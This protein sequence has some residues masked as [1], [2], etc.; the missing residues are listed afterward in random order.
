[1]QEFLELIKDF[2]ITE[3]GDMSPGRLMFYGGLGLFGLTVVLLIVFLIWRP[4]YV[5]ESAAVRAPTDTQRRQRYHGTTDRLAGARSVSGLSGAAGEPS[6]QAAPA[7]GASG[8]YGEPGVRAGTPTAP[9]GQSAG[10]TEPMAQSASPTA[11]IGQ[12]VSPTA[13]LYPQE[14]GTA[15]LGGGGLSS[16]APLSQGESGPTRPVNGGQSTMPLA[17][18]YERT[19]ATVPLG[20]G[21]NSAPQ[22][23]FEGAGETEAHAGDGLPH[24]SEQERK[25]VR[26]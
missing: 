19:G 10:P 9:I 18:G 6:A 26:K 2:D 12:G 11:P 3:I 4:K 7:D 17:G 23:Y 22:L 20:S 24:G 5:P 13:P 16:T 25:E 8:G 21:G 14:G 1:M 15:P